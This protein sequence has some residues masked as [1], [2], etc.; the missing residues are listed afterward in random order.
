MSVQTF[1]SETAIE[2][3]DEGIVGR[4]SRPGEVQRDTSSPEIQIARDEIGALIDTD[5]CRESPLPAD[6]FQNPRNISAA[7]CKA[8]FQRRRGPRERIDDREHAELVSCR[9]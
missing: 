2:G 6:F 7:E 9:Q 5:R 4:L 8:R 3:L 1:R